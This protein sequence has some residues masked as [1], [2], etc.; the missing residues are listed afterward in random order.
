[1]SDEQSVKRNGG[2]NSIEENDADPYSDI[3]SLSRPVSTKHPPMSRQNRAAQ[4]AP[5]AALTG[6]EAQMDEVARDNTERM[7]TDEIE[8]VDGERFRTLDK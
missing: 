4:F 5:F 7:I 2:R 8:M 1:M 3:I 6:L